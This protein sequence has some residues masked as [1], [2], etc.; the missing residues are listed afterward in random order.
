MI[1]PELSN[2][3][4]L[5]IEIAAGIV[6]AVLIS[7]YFGRKQELILGQIRDLT[8]Q[9][10]KLINIMETRRRERIRWFKHHSLTV[11]NSV[12]AE[13]VKLSEA[14]DNYALE[15]NEQNLKK[16]QS[17]A[18]IGISKVKHAQ[19]LIIIREIPNATEYIQNP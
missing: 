10:S 11:L 6:I 1:L 16:I 15:N 12:K 9:Q 8:E 18:R 3:Q 14:L 13:Y 5:I 19:D 4:T 2:T 7:V 17:I